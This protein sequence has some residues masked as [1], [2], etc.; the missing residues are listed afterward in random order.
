VRSPRSSIFVGVEWL[1]GRQRS[2]SDAL[3]QYRRRDPD[4]DISC[5]TNANIDPIKDGRPDDVL[6]KV[7]SMGWPKRAISRS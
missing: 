7:V 4:I 5:W 1:Q 2:S 6:A 3:K